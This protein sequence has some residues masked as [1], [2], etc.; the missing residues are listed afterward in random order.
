LYQVSGVPEEK[1]S[2][3]SEEECGVPIQEMPRLV[4]LAGGM[5]WAVVG[6]ER[7]RRMGRQVRCLGRIVGLW[8]GLG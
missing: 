1:K 7:R 4:V 6:G 5:D 2:A 8:T 3:L